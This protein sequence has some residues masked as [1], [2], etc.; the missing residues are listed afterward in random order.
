MAE[1]KVNRQAVL[2]L[3]AAG[4]LTSPQIAEK[5][6]KTPWDTADACAQLRRDKRI[7][8]ART[9]RVFRG[10]RAYRINVWKLVEEIAE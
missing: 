6:G 9:D 5:L 3:L 2:D 8:I 10:S 4:P 7:E 1:A